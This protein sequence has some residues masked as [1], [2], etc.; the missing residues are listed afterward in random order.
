MT[1]LDGTLHALADPTRRRIFEQL[2]RR[3]RSVSEIARPMSM[4]LAAV[5]HHLRALEQSG[6][7]RSRKVGRVRTC[8]AE[9]A[10]MRDVELWVAARRAD[11]TRRLGRLDRWLAVNRSQTGGD[12]AGKT[13]RRDF[14]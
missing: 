4:S 3:P 13:K 14:E 12:A 10:A 2:I 9:L 5:G 6:L 7:V 1:A 11:W 8:H